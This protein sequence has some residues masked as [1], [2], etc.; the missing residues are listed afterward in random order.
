[1]DTGRSLIGWCLSWRLPRP[2]LTFNLIF[3]CLHIIVHM[4]LMDNDVRVYVSTRYYAGWYSTHRTVGSHIHSM[5]VKV[6]AWRLKKM[7]GMRVSYITLVVRVIMFDRAFTNHFSWVF[8]VHYIAWLASSGK[9]S[10]MI[11]LLNLW[12]WIGALECNSILIDIYISS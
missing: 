8:S 9:H 12:I 2:K 1:M 6:L 5:W 4:L 11:Y 3:Y 10:T 7:W